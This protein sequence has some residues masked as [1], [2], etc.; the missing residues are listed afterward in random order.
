M[1]QA[2]LDAAARAAKKGMLVVRSSRALTGAVG[3]NVEVNDDELNL[4]RPVS[5]TRRKQEFY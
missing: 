5:S 4:W 1:N 3:R 2:W